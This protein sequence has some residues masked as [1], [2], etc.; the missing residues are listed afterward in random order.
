[1]IE[2]QLVLK[3]SGN[4]W[5]N[6]SRDKRE[7]SLYRELGSEVRVMAKGDPHDKGRREEVESFQVYR[8]STRPLG[9]CIPIFLIWCVSLF[10]WA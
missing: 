9:Q 1:M 6:F 3:I 8:Y 2:Q 7:L 10:I 5:R 4:E